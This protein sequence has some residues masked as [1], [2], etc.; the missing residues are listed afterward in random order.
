MTQQIDTSGP[1][2]QAQPAQGVPFV[3]WS[4]ESEMRESWSTQPAQGGVTL[5]DFRAWMHKEMP[6][7]TVI[8]NSDWWAERIYKKFIALRSAQPVARAVLKKARGE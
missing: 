2:P 4:K 7:D 5:A 8:G 1:A 6:A 3:P